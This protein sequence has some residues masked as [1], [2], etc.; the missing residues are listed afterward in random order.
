MSSIGIVR[1]GQR[2]ED[3]VRFSMTWTRLETSQ[4]NALAEELAGV[5][6]SVSVVSRFVRPFKT[7]KREGWFEQFAACFVQIDR[8]A[9]FGVFVDECGQQAGPSMKTEHYALCPVM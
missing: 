7:K 4:Q 1:N 3:I 5:Y 9:A 2:A 8:M 6:I